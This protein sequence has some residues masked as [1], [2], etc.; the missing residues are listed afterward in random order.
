MA[1]LRSL[2]DQIH[3]PIPEGAPLLIGRMEECDIQISDDSISSQHAQ[4]LLENNVLRLKDMGSTNGTRVNYTLIDSPVVILHGDTVEFGGFSFTIDGQELQETEEENQFTEFKGVAPLEGSNETMR[5]S[6]D[7]E[8]VD[9]HDTQPSMPPAS[10]KDSTPPVRAKEKAPKVPVKP[11]SNP[12]G[13]VFV[14]ALAILILSGAILL[15]E[16]QNLPSPF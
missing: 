6:I 2:D 13:V 15:S 9:L 8:E 1:T 14:M 12:V 10:P 7:L 4:I 16:I 5:I 11:F 3:I